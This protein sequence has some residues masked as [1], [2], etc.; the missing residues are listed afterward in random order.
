MSLKVKIG[1]KVYDSAHEPIMLILTDA[2]KRNIS[3]MIEEAHKY[4]VWPTD[5]MNEQEAKDFMEEL[6]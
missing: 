3:N 2:D 4:L 6:C 1:N 5:V